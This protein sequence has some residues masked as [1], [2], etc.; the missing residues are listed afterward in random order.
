MKRL[1]IV[2]TALTALAA[3][4]ALAADIPARMPVKAP[5]MLPV[6][7]WTGFYLGV[8]IGGAWTDT[9]FGSSV[10]GFIGGGQIGYNWQAIGSPFV[11][12]I[13]ADF[14]GSTQS[15]SATVFVPFPVTAS[16][17]LPWFGTVR[18]RLG[19]AWDRVMIYATGGFAFQEV[20]LSVTAPGLALSSSE[21]SLGWTV[22]GGLEWAFFD[23]WSAK[24][25]YLYINTEGVTV[26]GVTTGRV[27]NNVGRAGVNYRF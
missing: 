10:S 7:N 26:L 8:N 6:Y 18:G 27:E 11:L 23:R 16:A 19:Y 4:S 2:T 15:K 22:G 17:D 3:S 24:F 1:L 25:E 5:V 13:E 12:G 21:T 9:D 14:Q 20:E